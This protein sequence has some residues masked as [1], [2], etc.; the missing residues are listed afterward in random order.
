MKR[1]LVMFVLVLLVG[2]GEPTDIRAQEATPVTAADLGELGWALRSAS[3]VPTVQ[4][5]L[6]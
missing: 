1:G 3:R 4:L 6:G 2:T 5:L